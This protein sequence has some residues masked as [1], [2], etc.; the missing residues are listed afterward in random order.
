[1]VDISGFDDSEI[2]DRDILRGLSTWLESS[3]GAGKRLTGIL[4]LHSISDPR[5]QGS[6]LRNLHMF[7]SLIGEHCFQNV[8]LG[9]TFWSTFAHDPETAE[10]R[11]SGL[12]DTPEFWGGMIDK[13]AEICRL[14]TTQFAAKALLHRMAKKEAKALRIQEELVVHQ[15]GFEHTSANNQMIKQEVKKAEEKLKLDT[16]ARKEAIEAEIRASEQQ[17]QKEMNAKHREMKREMDVERARNDALKEWQ[18]QLEEQERRAAYLRGVEERLQKEK[19]ALQE[20]EQQA[21]DLRK[22]KRAWFRG[23]CAR[24]E[25]LLRTGNKSRQCCFTP[26]SRPYQTVCDNCFK[27][28]GDQDYVSTCEIHCICV[29]GD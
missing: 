14:P 12:I 7:K 8:M 18:R 27:N 29:L 17:R 23:E 16:D 1:M 3:Y 21:L 15:L 20:A 6:A 28:L 10:R 19:I 24:Q 13:G 4:Y 11:E 25:R 9:T 2:S 26:N 5:M 22:Q